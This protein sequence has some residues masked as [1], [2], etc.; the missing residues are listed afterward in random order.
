MRLAYSLLR[1]ATLFA[2]DR[3]GAT[4]TFHLQLLNRKAGACSTCDNSIP[5]APSRLRKAG[6]RSDGC[7]G[8]PSLL[9][10]MV[11]QSMQV[12]TYL[13]EGISLPCQVEAK[14]EGIF[15]TIRCAIDH[16]GMRVGKQYPLECLPVPQP[17]P[18]SRMLSQ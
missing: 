12:P 14:P 8:K 7:D 11:L 13:L 5:Q 3:A 4:H 2:V 17:A 1:P 9:E 16:I 15:V 10:K 18:D 6:G